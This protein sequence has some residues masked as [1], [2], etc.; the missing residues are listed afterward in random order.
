MTAKYVRLQVTNID[1]RVAPK[2]L[3]QL[4]GFTATPFL[5]E[6]TRVEIKN[7]EK[8]G[9]H[10]II[11][12]PAPFHLETLKL[13]GIGLYEQTLKI[14][15]VHETVSSESSGGSGME[16]LPSNDSDED[17]I[18]Y[19]LLGT[20]LPEWNVTKQGTT[21]H[22]S[23]VEVCDAI[24]LEHSDDPTKAVK[25]LWGTMKGC[26]RIESQEIN[27][28]VGK[29]LVIR[30]KELQLTPIR[31]KSRRSQ[32]FSPDSHQK[33][34]Y[35]D[36][37]GVK[38]TIYDAWELRHQNISNELFDNIF[39]EMG[40][41]VIGQTRPQRCR[42]RKEFFNTNRLIIVKNVKEDGSKIDMGTTF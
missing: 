4:L 6:N 8:H 21:N 1:E 22:V 24:L 12:V 41:E 37:E 25:T 34:N 33:R 39:I 23:E 42:E 35:F 7:S 20:R 31:K 19:M 32:N 27:R 36:P 13:D 29:S 16:T 3:C 30:G 9:R 2:D 15:Q 10:A 26:F 14:C 5:I 18:L 28:Y 38:V 11:I 40:V 17:Q